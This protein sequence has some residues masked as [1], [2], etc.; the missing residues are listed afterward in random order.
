MASTNHY[1]SSLANL[2][3]LEQAIPPV[4]SKSVSQ[5]D[6]RS[7]R[8]GAGNEIDKERHFEQGDRQGMHTKYLPN[9]TYSTFTSPFD[10]IR[11]M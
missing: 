11:F 5:I 8:T 4:T 1:S 7:A 2:G 9:K 10:A 3:R 6:T